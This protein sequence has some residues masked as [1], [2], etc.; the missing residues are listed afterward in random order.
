MGQLDRMLLFSCL[1]V[2]IFAVI[3][4][5]GSEA[6]G[7][8]RGGGGGRSSSGGRTSSSSK[9]TYKYT[10][11]YHTSG[12]HGGYYSGSS[13]KMPWS[14]WKFFLIIM[15]VFGI[16]FLVVIVYCLCCNSHDT[17]KDERAAR[18]ASFLNHQEEQRNSD[19]PTIVHPP[20]T[21]RAD[22]PPS[23]PAMTPPQ[24]PGWGTPD[25]PSFPPPDFATATATLIPPGI[26]PVDSS[27]YPPPGA[28]T[29]SSSTSQTTPPQVGFSIP[30]QDPA[31]A[32]VHFGG[33]VAAE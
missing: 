3:F 33:R 31:N 10:N 14:W 6:K 8:G 25:S 28:P 16:G 9:S 32:S 26:K 17:E 1:V 21:N 4:L 11:Y 7:G 20:I 27:T 19:L 13:E 15:T 12:Y 5:Q 24:Y 22:E 30:P 2:G 29:L 18:V 23:A